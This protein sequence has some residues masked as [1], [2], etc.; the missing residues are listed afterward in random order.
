MNH[1]P[2]ELE[3]AVKIVKATSANIRQKATPDQF[4]DDLANAYARQADAFD[5]LLS[6]RAELLAAVGR[7]RGALEFYADEDN[8]FGV[9]MVGRGPMSEDWS[10]DG[11]PDWPDGKPGRCAREIL[12]WTV[13]EIEARAALTTGEATTPNAGER[14]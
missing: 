5:L 12:G 13:A 9:Y 10:Q 14:E 11:N 1:T 8:W 7:M 2:D 4:G 6:E 3:L